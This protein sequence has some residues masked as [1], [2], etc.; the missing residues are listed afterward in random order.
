MEHK[1][2][3]GALIGTGNIAP[4]HLT[5]WARTPGVAIVALGNRTI[6]K[7]QALASQFGVSADRVYGDIEHLLERETELDFVD[8]A[9]APD[10]HRAA[11]E[12]AAARGVHVFCQKPLAPS[13]A[14]AEAMA[15]ACERAG[16]LLSVNENW[17]WRAWYR[18]VKAIL[19]E[20]RLGRL[21]Y[22]RIGHHRNVTLGP[23]DG[24]LPGL[25]TGQAY[26]GSLPHLILYEWGI[27]LLDTLRYLLGEAQW[28][29]AHMSRVSP[30]FKG[31]DRA[32]MAVGFGDVVA[33]IDISWASHAPDKP[34]SL[35][36]DVL[37]EGDLGSLALVPNQG[38]GDLLRVVEPLQPDEVPQNRDQ[39][40][41]PVKISA[42][43]AHT[44]DLAAAYQASYD[45]THAHFAECLRAGRLP[46]T[47]AG[48]NLKTLRLTFAAY[49]AAAR[50]QV[51]H[52]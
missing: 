44:G 36:E 25:L 39:I 31:E 20:G 33:S 24:S 51:V 3:R 50:N 48:D 46:E 30:H 11:T 21:R 8:I 47:H 1:S 49:E 2:L 32:L 5:A 38:T 17:R 6:E 18:Q 9:L 4:F 45:A 13:L 52:V 7:A 42:S 12:A 40:W 15:A 34:P 43:A 22:V 27:H 37:I 19:D 23:P 29:H 28:V 26:T 10:R 14:D 35:L 41:S 16:V